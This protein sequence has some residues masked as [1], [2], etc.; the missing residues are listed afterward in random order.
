VVPLPSDGGTT[1]G[2][3]DD[4]GCALAAVGRA[5]TPAHAVY[6]VWLV[7]GVMFTRRARR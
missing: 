2:N 1:G 7:L 6:A 5:N 3:A 4:D